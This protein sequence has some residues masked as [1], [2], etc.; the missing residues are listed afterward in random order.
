MTEARDTIVIR[1]PRTEEEWQQVDVL[2]SELSAW[3]VRESEALGFVPDDVMSLF[4]SDNLGGTRQES[5]PPAGC[6]LFAIDVKT[7]V[8]VAAYRQL[9]SD[10][11]EL[12]DVYV[13][14]DCRG[15]GIASRLLRTLMSNAKSVGYRAM[16][17][18]TA[19]FMRDAH[20]L[21]RALNFKTR[22]PYRKIPAKFIAATMWMECR[23]D[24]HG[25][26]Q[27]TAT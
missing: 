21:Y 23:L 8:G 3:D 27:N 2:L 12:H 9:T 13:R 17:L 16:Y 24:D 7:P 22:E 6:L 15:R 18:E 25:Q 4:H 20:N 14:P 10:A 26:G 1:S 5:V 11:C 19:T